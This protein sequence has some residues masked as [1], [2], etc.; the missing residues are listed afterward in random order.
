MGCHLWCWDSTLYCKQPDLSND[1]GI[2]I[3]LNK[4]PYVGQQLRAF[5]PRLSSAPIMKKVTVKGWN[6]ETKE[7]ITGEFEA[8][9]SPLGSEHA[10]AGSGDLGKE[11]TFTVDHPIWSKEEA[12]ALAKARH[13][14]LALT[15][16]TGECETVGDPSY[17]LGKTVKIVPNPDQGSDVFN[18]KYYVMGITHRHTAGGKDKGGGYVTILR[19]AR[20]AQKGG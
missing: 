6:P 20:D 7:L 1:S 14:D 8:Q 10:V 15:F 2:E 13:T 4:T 17:E 3:K 5:T 12:N 16:I 19:V 18:G 11:E 9:G